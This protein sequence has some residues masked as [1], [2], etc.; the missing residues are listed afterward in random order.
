MDL[1][2]TGKRALV[3][4]ASSGLGKA[5]AQTL[6][7]EGAQVAICARGKQRLETTALEIGASPLVCDLSQPGAAQHLVEHAESVI[8]PLDILITNTG[9]PAPRSAS[10]TSRPEAT[11]SRSM[12][13][14]ADSS[15]C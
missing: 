15:W 8:G 13:S 2:L 11:S 10:C 4:G 14:R 6:R 12:S 7:Q 1:G 5:I 3:M 9:G